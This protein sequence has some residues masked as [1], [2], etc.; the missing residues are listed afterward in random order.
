M[1]NFQTQIVKFD[2]SK[3]RELVIDLWQTVFGYEKAHNLPEVVIDK[4]LQ[5]KDNLFFVVEDERKVV[6]TVMA[7][8]DGH[9]GWIYSIAVH[10]EYQKQGIGSDLLSF[11]QGK[12]EN[13]GCLKI[14]LQIL[15]R[16]E[17]VQKFYLANGYSVEKRVSMGKKL[18]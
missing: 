8:Y 3:H 18:Y 6:G 9:R 14:N 7:G 12:L 5:N 13:L 4:K 16:N 17:T 1:K 10:L 2:N 11:I 15:Q